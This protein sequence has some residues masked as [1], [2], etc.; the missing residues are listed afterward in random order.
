[1][2]ITLQSAPLSEIGADWL[3]AGIWEKENLDAPLSDVDAKLGGLLGSLRTQGDI[4]G[5][6]KELTPI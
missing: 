4:S 2:R 5:K 6:A 3:I 1:M